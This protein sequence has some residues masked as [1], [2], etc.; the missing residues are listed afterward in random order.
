VRCQFLFLLDEKS[1]FVPGGSE[2]E[3]SRGARNHLDGAAR[4]EFERV[5][6][7]ACVGKR[8]SGS[9]QSRSHKRHSRD[10][11]QLGLSEGLIAQ[12]L[13]DQVAAVLRQGRIGLKAVLQH[14]VP[15]SLTRRRRRNQH[16]GFRD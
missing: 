2:G 10:W 13:L 15:T 14:S 5:A 3:R 4:S 11:V 8:V 7:L 9:V 1:S 6:P 12:E 16:G